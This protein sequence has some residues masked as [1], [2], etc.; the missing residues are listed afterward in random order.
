M[1]TYATIAKGWE[2][3]LVEDYDTYIYTTISL[4]RSNR[5]K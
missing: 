5:K 1:T 3:R 2:G 4:A